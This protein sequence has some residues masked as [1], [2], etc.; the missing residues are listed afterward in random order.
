MNSPKMLA[1]QSVGITF[2]GV[3][4]SSAS[5]PPF[6]G[7]LGVTTTS[8]TPT[9]TYHVPI[10]AMG[11]DPSGSTVMLVLSVTVASTSSTTSTASTTS[12]SAASSYT[13]TTSSCY[14]PPCT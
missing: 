7:T 6:S 8:S 4:S 13:H 5:D 11:D 1:F 12:S 9:G 2:T 10:T 14:Y 3:S